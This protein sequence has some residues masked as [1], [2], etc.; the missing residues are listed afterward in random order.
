[1]V[2]DAQAKAA[3]KIPG[4]SILTTTNLSLCDGIHNTAQ[5]NVALGEKLAKQCA[6]VLNGAEEYQPPK[7]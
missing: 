7:L 5:A 6:E 1:M 3:E 4:V 2:R